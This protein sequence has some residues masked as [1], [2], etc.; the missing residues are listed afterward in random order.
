M[1]S[2]DLRVKPYGL[3]EKLQN[4]YLLIKIWCLYEQSIHITLILILLLIYIG[5]K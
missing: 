4:E 2:F 3:V 1:V 5:L